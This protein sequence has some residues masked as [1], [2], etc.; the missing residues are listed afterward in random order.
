MGERYKNEQQRE[1]E[2]KPSIAILEGYSINHYE[3]RCLE[4]KISQLKICAS[5]FQE[6]LF[7]GQLREF[8]DQQKDI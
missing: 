5:Q 7:K 4:K 8:N 2:Q 3:N 1:I 6:V